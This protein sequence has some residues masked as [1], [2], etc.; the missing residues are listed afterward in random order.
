MRGVGTTVVGT[1]IHRIC[2][3]AGEGS[4]FSHSGNAGDTYL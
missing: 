3:I 1:E 2:S 4:D